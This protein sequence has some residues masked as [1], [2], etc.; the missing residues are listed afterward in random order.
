M[1][2][3]LK[4]EPI[5]L[6]LLVAHLSRQDVMIPQLWSAPMVRLQTKVAALAQ[7]AAEEAQSTGRAQGPTPDVSPSVSAPAPIFEAGEALDGAD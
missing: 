3:D 1:T 7:R 6:S 2:L 4:L 5:E